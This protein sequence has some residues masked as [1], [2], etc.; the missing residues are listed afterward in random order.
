M[1]T[2]SSEISL[3]NPWHQYIPLDLYVLKLLFLL[4]IHTETA[5]YNQNET[6]ELLSSVFFNRCLQKMI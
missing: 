5:V 4:K 1:G 3:H 6:L 2:I